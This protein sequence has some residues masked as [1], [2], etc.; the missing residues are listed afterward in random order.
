MTLVYLAVSVLILVGAYLLRGWRL[1]SATLVGLIV[2][3]FGLVTL[4]TST[5]Q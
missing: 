1:A 5:M 4:A 2:I 3:Y